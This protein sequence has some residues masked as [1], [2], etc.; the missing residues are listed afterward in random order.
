MS[1]EKQQHLV[2]K[3]KE[4][5]QHLEEHNTPMIDPNKPLIQEFKKLENQGSIIVPMQF[6]FECGNGWYMILDELM[7]GIKNHIWNENRNRKNRPKYKFI[8][9][10]DKQRYRLPWKRKKLKD[11]IFW[12]VNKFPR[13][14]APMANIQVT[15]IKE[16][17][18]G[19]NFYY[20]GGDDYIYGLVHFAESLS[21]KICENCGTT[22]NVG[23]TQ[24]WVYTVCTKCLKKSGSRVQE[25]EWLPVKEAG[26]LSNQ[27]KNLQL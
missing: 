5:F 22:M 1:P 16:K 2:E 4:F 18:G 20:Y 3:Y 7:A 19:L 12:F 24:G 11:F 6:G 10:L 9:W 14:I 21:Y 23:H 26:L 25:R 17:F 13:G 15:Q 8:R 27:Y